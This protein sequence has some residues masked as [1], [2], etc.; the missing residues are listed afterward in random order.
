MAYEA[1]VQAAR[2]PRLPGGWLRSCPPERGAVRSSSF[3]SLRPPP[4]SPVQPPIAVR[5]H[6]RHH[7][8]LIRSAGSSA[9]RS[10]GGDGGRQ[11]DVGGHEW[12]RAP[13]RPDLAAIHVRR[14]AR[15]ATN[16]RSWPMAGPH[17]RQL[18]GRSAWAINRWSQPFDGRGQLERSSALNPPQLSTMLRDS[19]RHQA[20]RRLLRSAGNAGLSSSSKPRG[21]AIAVRTPAS[22]STRTSCAVAAKPGIGLR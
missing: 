7:R 8:R 21:S 18:S 6:A 4:G 9:E 11:V 1:R 2:G 20:R 22:Q 10:K 14:C 15:T 5:Q 19:P 16:A 17:E 12:S 13:W 3:T